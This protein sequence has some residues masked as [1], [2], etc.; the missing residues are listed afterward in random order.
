MIKLKNKI[1]FAIPTLFDR[2]KLAFEAVQCLYD[3][4][5][6]NN[7]DYKIVL[8]CNTKNE[9]FDSWDTGDDKVIKMI[10]NSEYGIAKALNM[11][12]NE[13][14][15]EDYFVFIHDDMFINDENWINNFIK[16]Y[17]NK[18][19]SCGVLGIRGHSTR[20]IYCKPVLGNFSYKMEE[21][22]WTDG[23]MFFST[24]LIDK[25]GIFDESYFGDCESQDF[26]YRAKDNGYN[27]YM[28]YI[29]ARHE[30]IGFDKKDGGRSELMK[31]V[32]MSR[33]LFNSK[34]GE[35]EDK[36]KL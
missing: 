27:N 19:L 8:V 24:K 29:D 6:K 35:W 36:I 18:D 2:P 33:N 5:E 34:W 10:S 28:I 12:V 3:Q 4:C 20:N 31:K 30:C 21:L 7:L 14:V 9:I 26:C 25:I 16:I 32:N 13:I 23:I 17:Q 22:L 11:V 1:I 15:D